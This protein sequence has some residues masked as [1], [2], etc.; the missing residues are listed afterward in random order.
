MRIALVL[1]AALPPLVAIEACSSDS[2]DDVIAGDGDAGTKQDAKTTG[3]DADTTSDSS[4]TTDAKIDVTQDTGPVSGKKIFV[5]SL[6]YTGNLGGTTGAD[7]KCT[8]RAVAANVPGTFKAWIST[9]GADDAKSRLN[10][11][12]GAYVRID[13]VLVANDWNQLA[14]NA[15]A[16]AIDIDE[17]GVKVASSTAVWTNT[18]PDGTSRSSEHCLN[19]ASPSNGEIGSYGVVDAKDVRWTDAAI[20]ACEPKARLYCVEQ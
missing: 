8:A 13:G 9:T 15:H 10:H 11:S 12:S 20:G 7:A 17:K 14:S 6:D 16:A 1:L 2:D 3:N 19:W 5:T 4:D 18:K